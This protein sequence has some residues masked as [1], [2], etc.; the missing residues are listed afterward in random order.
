MGRVF[1]RIVIRT[2]R[3]F[4]LRPIR[5]GGI[6]LALIALAAGALFLPTFLSAGGTSLSVSLPSLPRAGGEPSATANYLRANRDYDANLMWASLSSGAQQQMSQRGGTLDDLQRQMQAAKD[7]GVKVEEF[8]Y[9]GS[10]DMGDGTSLQSYLVG[11]RQSANPEVEYV[12]YL[13]TLDRDG[14]IVRVQ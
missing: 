10:K 11:I 6:F 5:S 2:V 4:V 14:K 12:P 8:S 1:R 13:F 3:Y 7:R 9:M